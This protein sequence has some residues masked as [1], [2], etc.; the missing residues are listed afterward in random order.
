[1]ETRIDEVTAVRQPRLVSESR[2][3]RTRAPLDLQNLTVH[4]LP[5]VS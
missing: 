2:R 3:R 5:T 4:A 1:M